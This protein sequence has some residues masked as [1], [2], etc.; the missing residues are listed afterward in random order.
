MG[1]RQG[2]VVIQVLEPLFV[3]L[4]S[5]KASDAFS[6]DS[7]IRYRFD[8]SYVIEL[9]SFVTFITCTA[10]I[11]LKITVGS[12][13]EPKQLDNMQ[14][15]IVPGSSV[16]QQS[17]DSAIVSSVVPSLKSKELSHGHFL[18]VVRVTTSTC[19][20]I[21]SV[22]MDHK[23]LVWSPL[24]NPI[25]VPTQLPISGRFLPVTQV[26]MSSSGSL[27]AVFS[28]CGVVKC[29][30]RLSMSWIWTIHAGGLE[31]KQ[32]LEAFFRT[33]HSPGMRSRKGQKKNDLTQR[34]HVRMEK[35]DNEETQ[36]DERGRF[37]VFMT[38][39]ESSATSTTV[40][41]RMLARATRSL[42]VDSK[43]D[44]STD[45][46]KLS[47]NTEKDFLIVLRNGLLLTIDCTDG[48]IEKENVFESIIGGK[49][50]TDYGSIVACKKLL[51]P[52]M[53][54]RIVFALS[55]GS[56]I[57][58]TAIGTKWRSRRIE[59]KGGYNKE[60]DNNSGRKF[61]YSASSSP[62]ILATVPFVG[63]IV[64]VLDLWAQLIDVQSGILLKE[65]PIGQVKEGT[66]RVFHPEPSH[67]RFCGCASVTS[68]SVAYTE[69]ESNT[70]I[71]HTF[72][73]ENRAK[74]AICLRV[75]RDPRETRCLGFASVTQH[76]HWLTGVE[77]W[78]ATDLDVVMGVRQKERSVDKDVQ[79]GVLVKCYEAVKKTGVLRKRKESKGKFMGVQSAPIHHLWEGFTMSAD[80]QVNYYEIPNGDKSGLLIKKIGPVEKFGHKSIVASFGNVMKV[81]YLG[82]DNL[83][84]E[85]DGESATVA[86]LGQ[87]SNSLSFINRRRRLHLRRYDLTHSANFNG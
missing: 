77:G 75:E 86:N 51:T 6:P 81:L 37:A 30:S 4:G 11:A 22:G 14:I 57:V 28:K 8:L 42:S 83:I 69:L 3:W 49:K 78:G 60:G 18:D 55:D 52:R 41:S 44:A 34:K 47:D 61:H 32:P 62:V 64:R 2:S 23:V 5:K 9:A 1:N 67:C 15:T 7:P 38:R 82:N 53:N 21:I 16:T 56:L 10:F 48:S 76:Q 58:S 66:F 50:D 29:W 71:L 13:E 73:M 45:M 54:D 68:F 40:G 17:D 70:L 33:R 24:M 27:I 39:N 12:E 46:K 72:S 35:D 63:M 26:V 79:G 87:A 80:G 43:F 65:W 85:G 31:N 19:P 20:F 84:E 74:N 36:H 25:P 59:A